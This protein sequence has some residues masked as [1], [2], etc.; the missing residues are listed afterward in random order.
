MTSVVTLSIRRSS[1]RSL[2]FE[3][4]EGVAVEPGGGG[5]GAGAF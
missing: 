4:S 2:N 5:S 1:A 3:I